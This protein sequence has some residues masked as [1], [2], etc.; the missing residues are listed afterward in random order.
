MSAA[1]DTSHEVWCIVLVMPGEGPRP[2]LASPRA[3]TLLFDNNQGGVRVLNGSLL[4][5]LWQVTLEPEAKGGQ[6]E[7]RDRK[8][9]RLF[10]PDEAPPMV[11]SSIT[12]PPNL[13]LAQKNALAYAGGAMV[14]ILVGLLMLP[15]VWIRDL[16]RGLGRIGAWVT[17]KLRGHRNGR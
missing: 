8:P 15:F 12:A 2:I 7:A 14:M 10:Y 16:L 11:I 13:G 9:L 6:I 5:G 17:T 1:D 4:P 3:T